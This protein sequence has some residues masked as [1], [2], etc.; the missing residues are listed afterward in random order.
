[1][2]WKRNPCYQDFC[3]MKEF[4]RKLSCHST[5]PIHFRKRIGAEGVE[6]IFQMSVG[7]HGNAASHLKQWLLAIPY[8]GAY[9]SSGWPEIFFNKLAMRFLEG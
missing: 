5:E 2:Q 6:R 9:T 8:Y 7:L 4:Q 1:M 3:G